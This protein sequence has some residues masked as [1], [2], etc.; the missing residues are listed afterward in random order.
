MNSVL[1]ALLAYI[2]DR[3]FG[4]FQYIKHP[5]IYIGELISFFEDRFY[6]DSIVRGLFLVIFITITVSVIAFIL[7]YCFGMLNNFLNIILSSVVASMFLAHK[8]LYDSVKEILSSQDKKTAISMLVSRDTDVMSESDIYKASIETYAENLSDGVIAPL[9]YL[10]VFGLPGV[11]IYRAINTM[12]SM[13]G[14]RNPKY[15]N[16]GKTAAILDDIANYIPSRFT[17]ILIMILFQHRDIFLFFKDGSK[18]DSPNAGHPI[19]AMALS[20]DIKLGG[21]TYYF[22]K[23]KDKPYFGGGRIDIQA[24]DLKQ[25]LSIRRRVDFAVYIVLGSLYLFYMIYF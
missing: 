12:D 19:T 14:Y 2:I 23:L 15:E 16:Y 11:I 3:I 18:H 13:V 8:M 6:K 1:I 21:P 4:E 7:E 17:A 25:A 10:S 9:F 20:L 22:S 24:S 5:I